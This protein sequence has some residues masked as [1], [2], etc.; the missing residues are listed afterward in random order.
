MVIYIKRLQSELALNK[1]KTWTRHYFQ[2]ASSNKN[3]TSGHLFL[4]GFDEVEFAFRI[5]RD[6]ITA[7]L[8]E[9]IE[10]II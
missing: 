8:G 9:N 7:F 4:K 2:H 3:H 6:E 10:R 1:D 5:H